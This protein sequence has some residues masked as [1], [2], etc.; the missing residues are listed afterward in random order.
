MDWQTH[1]LR[2]ADYQLWANQVLFDSLARLEPEALHQPQGL[3][4]H[5]IAHTTDHLL[6]VLRLW[7]G[8]LRGETVHFELKTLHHPDWNELK[9]QLQHELRAFR[10][11]LEHCPPAFFEGRIAYARLGGEVAESGVADV[12]IHLMNHFTHHRG[13]VSAVATRLGAP[14]P[15]MDYIYFVRSMERAA[16]EVQA[17]QAVQQQ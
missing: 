9:H 13:Q 17:H 2:Q 10:H 16:R 14:A 1:F 12:L 3:F 5:S 11:W 15:E 6:T 7:E 8:R 4:F